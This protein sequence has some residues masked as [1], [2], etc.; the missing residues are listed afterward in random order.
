MTA[1][2]HPTLREFRETDLFGVKSLVHRTIAVCY[3]GHYCLEAV[4]FFANYHDEQAIRRDAK[5]G[6][7]LVLEKAGRILATG[8][9]VGD[10][11]K[12]V[13]VEP[14]LQK[15]GLG[16][17]IMRRL[18]EK[19]ADAGHRGNSA[20]CLCCPPRRSMTVSATPPWRRRSSAW[21]T[22]GV[23]TSSGCRNTWISGDNHGDDPVPYRRCLCGA[24]VRGQSARGLPQCRGLSSEEMQKI[25]KEM[26]FS[27]TTFILSDTPRDGGYDV[28][29]FTPAAEVPF[30]GHPTLGTAYII[31]NEI[32]GERRGSA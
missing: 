27:E 1:R 15:H 11:I 6:C 21:R 24:K 30:A 25:A 14:G 28:R 8:T 22:T 12:R 5:E 31:R 23:W 9:L 17:L 13:F 3:P 32:V 18:E 20:G 2:D 19:A 26:G 4:R 29:I 7:T 16:R 10:E